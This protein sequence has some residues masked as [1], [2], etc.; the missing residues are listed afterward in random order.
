MYKFSNMLLKKKEGTMNKR[1]LT[2]KADRPDFNFCLYQHSEPQ[3]VH[4]WLG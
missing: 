2:S 4:V 1:K 3:V